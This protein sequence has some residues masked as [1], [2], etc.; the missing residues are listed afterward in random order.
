MISKIA[1]YG[2]AAAFLGVLMLS[3]QGSIPPEFDSVW[4]TL[5]DHVDYNFHVRP[6]LSDRC[7]ACHGPD[8]ETQESDLRLDRPE[9]AYRALASGDGHAIVPGNIAESSLVNRILSQ[10]YNEQMPPPETNLH[11]ELREKAILVKWIQQ[12]AKYKDHWAF[13][14]P[15]QPKVPNT[16][17]DWGINEIDQFVLARLETKE[18]T[19]SPP[20]DR[21]TLVRRLYFDLTG[22]PPTLQEIDRLKSDARPNYYE[23]LVDSLLTLPAYGERMASYWL[24][25]ARFADSEGYLDDFH[26][27]F[28]PHRDWVINAY[29]QNLPYDKFIL[30]QLG[31]D[32]MPN[33]TQEQH[34]A[35]AFNRNHKQN[36][37]GGIIPEEFRVE[38]VADRTNTV[39]TAFLGLTVGCARCH[40]HK[41]DPFSQKNYYELFAFFNSTIERGDG[42]FGYNAVENGNGIPN[43]LSMNAGPVMPI[44]NPKIDKIRSFLQ[45]SIELLSA[46]LSQR[47]SSPTAASTNWASTARA[48]PVLEQIVENATQVH[49][50]FD[51]NEGGYSV[52]EAAGSKKAQHYGLNFVEGKKGLAIQSDAQ[53]QLTADGSRVSFERSEP[54]TIS[55]WIQVPK[56]FD[57]AHVLYNGN[58]RI[59]GYRGWDI[60]IQDNRL[61]FR[62][63]HAHP[64][65]SI[66]VFTADPLPLHEWTHFVWSYD[67]SSKASGVTIYQD[68]KEIEPEVERDFLYRSTKPYTDPKATVYMPYRGMIIGNRHYDQ[69]FTGGRLDELRILNVEADTRIAAYLFDNRAGMEKMEEMLAQNGEEAARFYHRYLDEIHA[70]GHAQLIEL[71]NCEIRTVDTLL[72]LMVMGDWP[73][74]RPTHVLNRGIYD[75]LGDEVSRDVPEDILP[76]PDDLP[77]NRYGLGQWLVHPDHPLTS[78]V[79]VNQIWYL[80]FGEGIV[81][82]I[83]D[84]GSQGALPTHP[85]LLDWLAVDFRTHGWDVKR[86][87]KQ[88]VMSNTYR[89][90]SVIRPELQASDPNNVLLA[91]APRYRRSA[92]MVRDNLLAVSGLLDSRLGGASAFPYQPPDLW[93]EVSAHPF[94]PEYGTD[95]ADGLYRRSLYTF[96][97]RN[98]PPPSMLIFD[99]SSRAECVVK[100]QKSNTPL[101]ALVMLNDPQVIEA[102]RSL[103]ANTIQGGGDQSRQ[104]S[105]TFAK[106]TGRQPSQTELSILSDQLNE[107][108]QYFENDP[109]ARD[110]YLQTGKYEVSSS[111]DLD[112]VAALARVA[113]TI[114]NSTEGYY[115]N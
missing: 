41:Y 69:D 94:F 18:I 115:K 43:A 20:A 19:P 35:T 56:A 66:S 57:E 36:S 8:A 42:I 61:Y 73:S 68:G 107:E 63:S 64:Y 91:R 54:F 100:R 102:C 45:D 5:P 92:E 21:E 28:W 93:S 6:I 98:M 31:G 86:L 37:E 44:G 26:H 40:D 109:M 77:K 81:S 95:Y 33:A 104:L 25:V 90:A 10:D 24:D 96:W 51:K 9:G 110:A 103:A 3:C 13:T 34:L 89:Q 112:L 114:A 62:L 97:K 4:D 2:W 74:E 53:G 87:V 75:D 83:E 38:Y 50:P 88:M 113:N 67:G 12:G 23:H 30:W 80:M 60:M 101:Q 17:L 11:L 85:N 27:T 76:W 99:A 55:F 1:W 58:N 52:D 22:L 78:R 70:Q 29:N 49:L 15:V 79:A 106:L 14:T 59:Q 71:R 39:G 72:E 32:Q 47:E 65:Q 82:T 7:F 84:F 105:K 48:R 46:H 16:K 111:L 108:L